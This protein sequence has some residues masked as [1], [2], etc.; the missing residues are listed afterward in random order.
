MKADYA[1]ISIILDRTGS[2][3]SIRDDVIGGFN[4]FIA[5]HKAHS[6][7]ASLTLVQFDSQNPYEVIHHFQ[8]IQEV[9][10]LTRETYVPRASTPLLDAMGRGIIDLEQSLRGR[11]EEARPSKVI[12]AVVTD[13]RENASREFRKAQIEKMV[14]EKT[15]RDGWEIVFLSADLDAIQD[16]GAIGV[17]PGRRLAFAKNGQGTADAW[18]SLSRRTAEV[19]ANPSRKFGF[20]HEDRKHPKDPDKGA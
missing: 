7:T 5:E 12:L 19:R 18:A 8:S 13:G 16:A 11:S 3:E 4:T 2:M 10:A 14:K 9:P 6:G 15:E 17:E 1:H 20:L